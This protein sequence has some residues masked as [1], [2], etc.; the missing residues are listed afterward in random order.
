MAYTRAFFSEEIDAPA[1]QV[2]SVLGAFNCLPAILPKLVAK[3]ELDKTGLVRGLTI[4]DGDGRLYKRYERLIKYD[5]LT[6]TLVYRL[7]DRP[8]S[9][10]PV[11]N[12]TATVKV[13]KITSGRCSVVWS[14]RFH[15]RHGTPDEVRA[16]VERV[17]AAAIEG[18]KRKIG[19]PASRN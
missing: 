7:I 8:R 12:Y 18:V 13:K 5:A 14:G 1:D 4:R 6:H 3:S 17:F 9:R 15:P 16:Q 10:V 19:I 11:R 2:W